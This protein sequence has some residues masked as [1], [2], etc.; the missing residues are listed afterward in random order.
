MTKQRF[1]LREGKAF[2]RP[3]TA[4][5]GK[6]RRDSFLAVFTFG[7]DFLKESIFSRSGE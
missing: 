5:K 1:S 3:I 7:N 4:G 2:F 6:E